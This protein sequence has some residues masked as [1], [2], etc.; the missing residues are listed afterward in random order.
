MTNVSQIGTNAASIGMNFSR[1]GLNFNVG[2]WRGGTKHGSEAGN[3]SADGLKS[4]NPGETPA[5]DVLQATKAES[6]SKFFGPNNAYFPSVDYYSLQ[7]ET[8]LFESIKG[9]AGFSAKPWTA[10][11]R[12]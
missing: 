12:G 5:K 9:R 1:A 7:R 8:A 3:L 6:M 10:S 2:Q 4:K 11:L